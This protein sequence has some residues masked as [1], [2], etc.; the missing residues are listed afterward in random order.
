MFDV[1]TAAAGAAGVF[2]AT[3]LDDIV[4][5]MVLFVTLRHTGRPRPW[6][7]VAGRYAASARSSR[8]RCW[9]PPGCSWCRTRGP[10]CSACCRSRSAYAR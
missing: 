10:A 8:S 3:N 2:A 5:L 1:I 4:V 6:Q 9:P 7:I